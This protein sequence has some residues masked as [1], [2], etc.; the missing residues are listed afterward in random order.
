MIASNTKPIASFPYNCDLD[1][2]TF[3]CRKCG[4]QAGG[5]DW[6][7]NCDGYIE[8]I[9]KM[10]RDWLHEDDKPCNGKERKLGIGDR[11]KQKLRKMGVPPCQACNQTAKKMNKLG[12]EGCK[13]EF[14]DL[15]AEILENMSRHESLIVRLVNAFPKLAKQAAVEKLLQGVIDKAVEES[16]DMG[17]SSE[18]EVQEKG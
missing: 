2:K 5:P 11:L 12:V 18:I 1:P 14:D 13:E 8:E 3:V 4:W 9:K 10:H 16:P 7:R 17:E 15:A 6:R